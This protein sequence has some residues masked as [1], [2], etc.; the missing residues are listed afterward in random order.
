M[1]WFALAP[2]VVQ[3]PL[4]GHGHHPPPAALKALRRLPRFPALGSSP[5]GPVAQTV[6]RRA[7]AGQ[8]FGTQAWDGPK[9]AWGPKGQLG[10]NTGQDPGRHGQLGLTKKNQEVLFFLLQFK[11]GQTPA[12]FWPL[13][14]VGA[15]C[16]RALRAQDF[17]LSRPGHAT[18]IWAEFGGREPIPFS[19]LAPVSGLWRKSDFAPSWTKIRFWAKV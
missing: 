2:P 17:G 10:R 14:G 9:G 11:P 19:H 6:P 13:L 18:G 5:R 15:L 3:P 16:G 12:Q 4:P 7:R 8:T 1:G